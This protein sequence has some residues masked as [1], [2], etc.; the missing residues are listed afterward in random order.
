MKVEILE[1]E[2]IYANLVSNKPL[3]KAYK[4]NADYFGMSFTNIS[5]TGGST[6]MGNV[7]QV[8][9]SIHPVYFIGSEVGPHTD[10]FTKWTGYYAYLHGV[11]L[12][13]Y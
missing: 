10:E 5:R 9:P 4:S 7:S 1:Y 11:V 2:E 6:D 3:L 8:I 13:S 12:I